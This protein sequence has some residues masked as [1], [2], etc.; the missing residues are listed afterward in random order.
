MTRSPVQSRTTAPWKICLNRL[1]PDAKPVGEPTR[2]SASVNSMRAFVYI[3]QNE[4]GTYYIGST[5]D[6]S[7][8]LAHHESGF[9]HSTKRLGKVSLVF[10]Q[11]Y[12]TLLDARRIEYRLKKLKR[13]DYIKK[14]IEEGI[15]RMN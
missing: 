2:A 14:I 6:I 15:I 3:L 7:K 11:E 10:S 5:V 1:S 12:P 9:T 13:K 8:R 4:Q